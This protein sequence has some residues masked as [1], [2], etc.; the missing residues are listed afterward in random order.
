METKREVQTFQIGDLVSVDYLGEVRSVSI[1]PYTK[2]LQ[3]S[4][5]YGKNGWAS[6]TADALS[7]APSDEPVYPEDDEDS[8][9]R[10]KEDAAPDGSC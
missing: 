5:D 9:T 4:I 2:K 10:S 7:P 8:Y 1:D 3:Y 6:V